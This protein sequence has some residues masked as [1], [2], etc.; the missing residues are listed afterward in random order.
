MIKIENHLGVIEISD[1]YFIN[2]VGNSVISC[3]GVAA[4]ST[5]DIKQNIIQ[6]IT[7]TEPLNKGIRIRTRNQKLVIE[8][9]IIVSYGTN[10]SEIVKSIMDNVK[11]NIKEKTGFDVASV[12]VYVDGMRPV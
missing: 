4:M 7:R 9:H 12:D 10:V 1:N 2:L 6:K 11:F 8:I 5:A 3:F